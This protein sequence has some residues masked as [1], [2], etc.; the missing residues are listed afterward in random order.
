[1]LILAGA[2]PWRN[3]DWSD[4]VEFENNCKVGLVNNFFYKKSEKFFIDILKYHRNRFT[5]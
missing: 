4:L 2:N 3:E 5:V 1:M